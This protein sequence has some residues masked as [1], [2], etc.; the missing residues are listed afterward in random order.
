MQFVCV[1]ACFYLFLHLFCFVVLFFFTYLQTQSLIV[2]CFWHTWFSG[3]GISRFL[4][5]FCFLHF[6]LLALY[7]YCSNCLLI[8]RFGDCIWFGHFFSHILGCWPFK[9][10][11]FFCHFNENTQ[12]NAFLHFNQNALW[13]KHIA[14]CIPNLRYD[15]VWVESV[16]KRSTCKKI[17]SKD[18]F[19]LISL[20]LHFCTQ[21]MFSHIIQIYLCLAKNS[22]NSEKWQK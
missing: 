21:T 12:H 3:F 11:T 19:Q 14:N 20:Y 1:F 16:T 15:K 4:G 7:V 10:L 18:N 5:H 8:F 9:F 6:L 13:S 2:V 17:M 22:H